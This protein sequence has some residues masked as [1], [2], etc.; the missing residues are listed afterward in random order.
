MKLKDWLKRNNW[1]QA[2]RATA[3]GERP[4]KGLRIKV[5]QGLSGFVRPF[6]KKNMKP[7]GADEF[8]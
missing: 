4:C 2:V 3:A 7:G 6:F 1:R 8:Q 5:R